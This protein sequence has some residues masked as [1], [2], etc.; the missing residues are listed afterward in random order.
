MCYSFGDGVLDIF[1]L[2]IRRPPRST[3]TAALFPYTTLFRSNRGIEYGD[4]RR[5]AG[6]NHKTA[7]A[8]VARA[9]RMATRES[10]RR[11]HET[12]DPFH[13]VRRK[14]VCRSEEHRL[15]SSH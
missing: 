8:R 3:R 6:S 7:A 11:E 13:V 2:R 9:C 15:N 12:R 1:F 10:Q 5:L 14:I 4:A